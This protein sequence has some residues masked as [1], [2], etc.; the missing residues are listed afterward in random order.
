[1]R[2]TPGINRFI[3]GRGQEGTYNFI[4]RS[5]QQPVRLLLLQSPSIRSCDLWTALYEAGGVISLPGGD[6]SLPSPLFSL[7]SRGRGSISNIP[8]IRFYVGAS[9]ASRGGDGVRYPPLSRVGRVEV[10]LFDVRRR[11]M[12]HFGRPGLQCTLILLF[13]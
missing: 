6:G 12:F 13:S 5:L 4:G 1:M 10:E 3:G 2:Q 8:C 7:Y 9:M 11:K